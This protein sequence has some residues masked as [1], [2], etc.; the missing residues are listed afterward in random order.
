MKHVFVIGDWDRNFF[1]NIFSIILQT[2][3]LISLKFLHICHRK[4]I[5]IHTVVGSDW[6]NILWHLLN[7]PTSEGMLVNGSEGISLYHPHTCNTG[8]WT[9]LFDGYLV[10]L[11]TANRKKNSFDTCSKLCNSFTR[12]LHNI[13]FLVVS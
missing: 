5:L 6:M 12:Q 8:K 10:Y 3:F 4:Q 13:S 1:C 7:L 9:S 11:Y 2:F